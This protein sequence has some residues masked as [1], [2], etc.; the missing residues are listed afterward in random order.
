MGHKHY[1]VGDLVEYTNIV[2][3]GEVGIRTD[4]YR[5]R[6]CATFVDGSIG[7]DM[8]SLDFNNRNSSIVAL[9][10]NNFVFFLRGWTIVSVHSLEMGWQTTSH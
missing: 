4:R 1:S 10:K 3:I 5:A 2:H 7:I 6:V 9:M 8:L